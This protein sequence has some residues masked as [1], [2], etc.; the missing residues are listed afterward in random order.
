MLLGILIILGV[1]VAMLAFVAGGVWLAARGDR[2]PWIDKIL[3]A[4]AG[5][6]DPRYNLPKSYTDQIPGGWDKL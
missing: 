6:V 3:R 1:S 5:M 2:H 4:E